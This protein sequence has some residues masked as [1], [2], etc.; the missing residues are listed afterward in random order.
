MYKLSIWRIGENPMKNGVL[1][2]N[3]S[4]LFFAPD[5]STHKNMSLQI[6]T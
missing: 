2:W 6:H 1:N 4:Y 5:G 3:S